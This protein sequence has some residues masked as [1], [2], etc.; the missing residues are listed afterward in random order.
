MEHILLVEDTAALREVLSSVLVSEGYQV[1][2]AASAEEGLQLF[3]E[4]DF[5]L[6]LSDLKLPNKS[7]LDFLKETK[8]L[9]NSVPVVVMTAYGEI[10]I[11]VQAMKLGASDFVTKPFDPEMLCSAIR[12][13]LQYRRLLDRNLTAGKR[14]GTR[15]ILTQSPAMETLL[16]QAK[17]VA[18]LRTPVMILGES[19]TGKDLLARYIHENSYCAE[20]AFVAVN[21]ASTPSDLLESEFFG[22]EAGA[23][24]G[25]SERR[26]GLFE[27]ACNGTIFLDEIGNMPHEL[28]VKLLRTLQESEIKRIGSNAVMRISTRVIS[29]TNACID[30]EIRC[31]RF[32]SD[33]YYRLGVVILEIPPLR[34]RPGDVRLLANYFVKALASELNSDAHRITPEAMRKLEHYSWPGNIRELENA[35]ERAVIF[36]GGEITPEHLELGQDSAPA[37]ETPLLPLSELTAHAVREAEVAAI[38]RAMEQTQGNKSKAAKLLGISYKTLLNKWRD[39]ALGETDGGEVENG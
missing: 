19:G 9:N 33:L 37:A 10:D 5:A 31:G 27:V 6:V 16:N 29:A 32:R 35:L 1:S 22:H 14:H 36:S 34:E 24:T 30:E 12:Q 21:C 7:G 18:P 3:R 23:F 17:K 25:A 13:I 2:S 38:L 28:Q 26:I 11:A 20:E 8:V 15:R 39:Y 4:R